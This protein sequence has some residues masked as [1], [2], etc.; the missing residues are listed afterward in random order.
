MFLN[1]RFCILPHHKIKFWFMA[2]H[3]TSLLLLH[4]LIVVLRTSSSFYFICLFVAVLDYKFA[5]FSLQKLVFSC[6]YFFNFKVVNLLFQSTSA[7]N[8]VLF[9]SLFFSNKFKLI[10]VTN[11]ALSIQTKEFPFNIL[12]H[13]HMC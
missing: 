11:L 10:S 3:Y 7:A 12:N 5:E 4:H 6:I 13:Q 2:F 8:F 1:I 9:L